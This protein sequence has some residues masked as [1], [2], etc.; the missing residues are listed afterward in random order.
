MSPSAERAV[1]RM[2]RT[3]KKSSR[4]DLLGTLKRTDFHISVCLVLKFLLEAVL[5]LI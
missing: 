5:T 1:R 4:L 2:K 3:T